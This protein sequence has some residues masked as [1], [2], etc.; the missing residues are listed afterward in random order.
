MEDLDAALIA[1][2]MSPDDWFCRLLSCEATDEAA[3]RVIAKRIARLVDIYSSQVR[4]LF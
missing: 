1:G 3:K 4:R 2:A